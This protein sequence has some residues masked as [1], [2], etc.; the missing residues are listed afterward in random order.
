MDAEHGKGIMDEDV[1]L[2][3]AFTPGNPYALPLKRR[4]GL[5]LLGAII[6]GRRIP[7]P[8]TYSL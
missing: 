3:L 5:N 2:V 8:K 7:L 6:E 1:Y 4:Q